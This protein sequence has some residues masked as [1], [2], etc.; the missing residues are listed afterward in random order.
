MKN[1]PVA[2]VQWVLLKR[3]GSMLS[4]VPSLPTSI[5]FFTRWIPYSPERS[6]LLGTGRLPPQLSNCPLASAQHQPSAH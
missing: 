3:S 2:H 5:L 4:S 6:A 1:K